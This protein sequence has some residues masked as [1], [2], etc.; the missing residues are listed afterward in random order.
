MSQ[1]TVFLES[2]V[3]SNLGTN[4][5]STCAGPSDQVRFKQMSTTYSKSGCIIELKNVSVNGLLSNL[6]VVQPVVVRWKRHGGSSILPNV[7]PTLSGAQAAGGGYPVCANF[8]SYVANPAGGGVQDAFYFDDVCIRPGGLYKACRNMTISVNGTSF[9]CRP[10]LWSS[11][12]ERLFV[13]GTEDVC[14]GGWPNDQYPYSNQCHPLSVLKE[15][16]RIS[17]CLDSDKDVYVERATYFEAGAHA[18]HRNKLQD[19]VIRYNL[20]TKIPLG[21]FLYSQFPHLASFDGKNRAPTSWPYIGNL[22]IQMDYQDNPLQYFFAYPG[23]DT[24]NALACVNPAQG[25]A[26]DDAGTFVPD[27]Q[28][29]WS[30]AVIAETLAQPDQNTQSVAMCQPYCEYIFSNPAPKQLAPSYLFS[31]KDFVTYEDFSTVT[32]GKADFAFSNI[33]LSTVPQLVVCHVEAA[34]QSLGTAIGARQPK[35]L[36]QGAVAR[37]QLGGAWSNIWA[38]ID[39]S[40]LRIQVSTRNSVLANFSADKLGISDKSQY[41][42]FR[43]YTKGRTGMSLPQWAES[44]KAIIFTAEELCLPEVFGSSYEAMTLSISFQ[45]D[46]LATDGLALRRFGGLNAAGINS[47]PD[48]NPY[49]VA[50]LVLIIP[51][52]D[53]AF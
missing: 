37:E 5:K 15:D 25:A 13:D 49:L 44:S 14:Y 3:L 38:P 20:R 8:E 32:N 27:L 39:Y 24:S 41:D 43:K 30:Q 28:L 50:R 52:G 9:S 48:T 40:T 23:N 33:K 26:M 17:R 4:E 12:V 31:S 46:K 21:P 53:T 36:N 11:A 10:Q 35:W 34:T 7:Y 42:V 6:E 2:D 29:M 1:P 45:T 19:I 47:R 16:K 51:T 18:D 22:V